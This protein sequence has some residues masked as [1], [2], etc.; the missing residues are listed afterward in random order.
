MTPWLALAIV[1]TTAA[2]VGGAIV[3]T[4]AIGIGPAAYPGGDG[5]GAFSQTPLPAAT[6]PT[7]WEDGGG[8]GGDGTLSHLFRR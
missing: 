5:A 7:P 6:V 3:R 8:E 2:C 4:E 1:L